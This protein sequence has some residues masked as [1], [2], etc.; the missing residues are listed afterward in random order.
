MV[1]LL[2]VCCVFD[3]DCFLV[4][5]GPEI[6]FLGPKAIGAQ[7]RKGLCSPAQEKMIN[8]HNKHKQPPH[9]TQKNK[10]GRRKMEDGR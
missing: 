5:C 6:L 10:E 4:F 2:V 8:S 7:N 3:D 9:N 1:V